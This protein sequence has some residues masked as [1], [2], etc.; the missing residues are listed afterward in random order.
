MMS[1]RGIDRTPTF[2][3]SPVMKHHPRSGFTLI[4]ILVV[5][6][7]ITILV[8]VVGINLFNKPGEARVA[9][10]RFQMKT[11]QTALQMY[12][13]EN[14]R[15]PTQAQGLEA[16]VLQPTIDPVPKNF[17]E[18][19]YLDSLTVPLDPWGNPYIYLQPGRNG[20]PFELISYGADGTPGGTDED[21]DLSSSDPQS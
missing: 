19:G 2:I 20:E 5:V 11:L 17:P 8:G 6:L 18:G 3:Q 14:S 4:E 9:A 21:G 13:T 15:L 10:A 12:R 16:L 1:T 7:I